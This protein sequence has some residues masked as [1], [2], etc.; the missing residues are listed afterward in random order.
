MS[1][2]KA[3]TKKQRIGNFLRRVKEVYREQIQKSA[4]HKTTLDEIVREELLPDFAASL[5]F[6]NIVKFFEPR[7]RLKPQPRARQPSSTLVPE[8]KIHVQIVRAQN[9]PIRASYSKLKYSGSTGDG[10]DGD[11]VMSFVDVRFQNHQHRTSAHEG[12]APIWNETRQVP[13]TLPFQDISAKRLIQIRDEVHFL[14]FDELRPDES[15]KRGRLG[16]SDQT[17]RYERRFLGSFSL[18]FST[19]YLNGRIRGNFRLNAPIS[20]LGYDRYTVMSDRELEVLVPDLTGH[21]QLITRYIR[22]QEP[23]PAL[24]GN[25]TMSRV[26]EIVRFVSVIPFLNDWHVDGDKNDIWC[27]S[28]QFLNLQAG[29]WEEHAILL[30]NYFLYLDKKAGRSD[31]DA[32]TYLLLGHGVPMGDC[33]MVLLKKNKETGG[34]NIDEDKLQTAT[35]MIKHDAKLPVIWDACSGNCY[36]PLDLNCPLVTVG[37]VVNANNVWANIQTNEEPKRM[38]WNLDDTKCWSACFQSDAASKVKSLQKERLEYTKTPSTYTAE[39]EAQI[40]QEILR[41]IRGWRRNR[42]TTDFNRSVSLKLKELLRPLENVKLGLNEYDIEHHVNQLK[43]LN[44][45]FDIFGFPIN[46]TFIEMKKLLAAVKNTDIHENEIKGVQFAIASLVQ[47]YT[48][49]VCSVWLYI[50]ALIPVR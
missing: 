46:V 49:H 21:E 17:Q 20:M 31:A 34:Q 9:V 4:I 39:L 6:G 35:D 27:T 29:D 48:N 5:D 24:A 44:H 1:G 43:R 33:C 11:R 10:S 23:P 15:T 3:A 18:P 30:C 16:R 14:L 47:S 25:V 7:R 2:R 13:I 42:F 38:N 26:A 12:P 40:D 36:S 41:A 37:C 22:P 45:T 8:C 50:A 28:E 19:I 32:R